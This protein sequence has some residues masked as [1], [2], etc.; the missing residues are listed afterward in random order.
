VSKLTTR[1]LF[2]TAL[3]VLAAALIIM[4]A[5]RAQLEPELLPESAKEAEEPA[6]TP[7]PIPLVRAG[8]PDPPLRSELDFLRWQEMNAR[9][10]Q[11]FVEGAVLALESVSSRLRGELEVDGTLPP[12]QLK[13]VVK[14]IAN[15]HPK[16]K[17][18]IY[19]HEMDSIYMTAEG[20]KLSLLECFLL[21]F[22]R[23]NRS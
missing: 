6:P 16:R 10:R 22:R 4:P 13:A 8:Q 5:A 15:N 7:T 12:E 11:V 23:E 14:F 9:E 17:A 20:Q 21:A 18:E 3:L 2:P 1:R 19:R